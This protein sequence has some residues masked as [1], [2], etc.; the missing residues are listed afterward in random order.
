MN[1]KEKIVNST[2]DSI[3]FKL[4]IAVVI[5][6]CF[7]S[8]IGQAVNLAIARGRDALKGVG[9]ATFFLD[10]A[11][12]VFV[13]AA[14]SII[15]S[16]FIIVYIYD[17]LV[18]KRLKKVLNFTQKLGDGDLSGELNFKGHD[19]ISKLGESLNKAASNIKLLVSDITNISKNINT[20]SHELLEGTKS[21]HT[22]ISAINSTSVILSNE[23]LNLIDTT[24][25]A[26]S[27]IEDIVK[28]NQLLLTKVKD[29]LTSSTEMETRAAQMKLKVSSSLE[30]ANITY[31]EKQ[32]KI[33]K[34][35]EAGKIV[36][37]IKIMSDTIKGIAS[38]TNLLALNASIEAARAGEQGKGFSVV[39][40]EVKKLAEQSTEA[41]S[42]VENLVT[43]VREVFDN[44]SVSSQD[45]LEYIDNNVKADY[46][47]LLETGD[48]YQKDAK[49]INNISTEVT[50]SAKIMNTSIEEISKVIDKVVDI[51]GKTSDSTSEINASLS[52]ITSIMNEVNNAME[53]QVSL[54]NGLEKSVEKFTL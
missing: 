31:S 30:K 23:A 51:S 32:E 35:I 5:V 34:A 24:Q 16:V 11:I 38:Q 1:I 22:S 6:Q 9:V 7:S 25:N 27:S 3:K 4:I 28:T 36:E 21:S 53:N 37:E 46:E 10:G 12:G 40:E 48:Q 52:E 47:L 14:I 43:Q 45:I 18:L 2:L 17:R 29:G 26:N 49:L 33:L 42:N 44:L 54:S 39:A 15:I 50:S 8:Y 13:S 41:I 20:S 19:D